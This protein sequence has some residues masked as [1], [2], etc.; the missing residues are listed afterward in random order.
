MLRMYACTR[1]LVCDG[2]PGRA[3]RTTDPVQS[4]LGNPGDLLD[5][6]SLPPH[7][8][9]KRS[10][11]RPDKYEARQS[12]ALALDALRPETSLHAHRVHVPELRISIHD[13]LGNLK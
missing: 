12:G 7:Q 4:I 11:I 5:L 2:V 13:T 6:P 8:S 3:A 10:V 9:S 1:M